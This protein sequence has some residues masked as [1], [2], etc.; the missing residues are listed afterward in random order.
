MT[1]SLECSTSARNR[2]SL[3]HSRSA[4]DRQAVL[5]VD[6]RPG[7]E[8]GADVVH[9]LLRLGAVEHFPQRLTEQL[10]G[11]AVQQ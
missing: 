4:A 5:E 8:G 6:G 3:A 1:T 9:E 7:L 2:C 10:G 11:R